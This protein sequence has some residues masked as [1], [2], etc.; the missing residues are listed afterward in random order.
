MLAADTNVWA[1]ALL[2]DDK[3]QPP[4]RNRLSRRRDL[5]AASSFLC[6]YWLNSRGCFAADGRGRK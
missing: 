1:R 2:E 5:R 4:R 6:S 3:A